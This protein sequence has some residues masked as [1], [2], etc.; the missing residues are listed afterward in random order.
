MQLLQMLLTFWVTYDNDAET[1]F[2]DQQLSSVKE[3]GIAT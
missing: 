1:L 2:L 3:T